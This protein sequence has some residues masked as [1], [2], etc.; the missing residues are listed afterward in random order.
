MITVSIQKHKFVFICGLHR[1]GTSILFKRLKQHRE[2]SGFEST[3]VSEDEGQLLQTVFPAAKEFGGPGKFGFR[4]EMHL[5]ENSKLINESNRKKL[6][7]E[8]SKYW[9][10]K[11]AILIEKSPPNLL[12]TRFLQAFFPNSIFI[13]IIRHPVAVAL[14][15]KRFTDK[16]FNKT[17]IELFFKHWIQCHEIYLDDKKQLKNVIDLKYE[18]FVETPNKYMS[19]I[20]KKLEIDNI[21]SNL[22]IIKTTNDKYFTTWDNYS[23]YFWTKKSFENIIDKYE[24]KY[25]QFGYSLI[26]Y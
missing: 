26:D 22:E 5:D 10:L 14:A 9:N 6:F 2:I 11:K 17:N 21:E 23:K 24:K 19:T 7:N 1:S 13:T 3:G 4:D 12:K 25:N 8:W 15:T 18:N 20:C 16:R